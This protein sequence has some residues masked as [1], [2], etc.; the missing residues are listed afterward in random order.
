M[1]LNKAR[2][3]RPGQ[4]DLLLNHLPAVTSNFLFLLWSMFEGVFSRFIK[5]VYLPLVGFPQ[6]FDM[7]K[8]VYSMKTN[9]LW[10]SV[11]V[12]KQIYFF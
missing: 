3:V 6:L 12:P 4:T 11:T 9:P 5:H 8:G 2:P 10:A 1:P 7:S